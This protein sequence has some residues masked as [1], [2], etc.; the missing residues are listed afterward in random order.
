MKT[1]S[2]TREWTDSPVIFCKRLSPILFSQHLCPVEIDICQR[3]SVSGYRLVPVLPAQ[4]STSQLAEWP[5]RQYKSSG[6]GN[7]DCSATGA[8]ID[9]GT[10]SAAPELAFQKACGGDQSTRN[11]HRPSGKKA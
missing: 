1:R 7:M 10:E 8:L 2:I 9:R 4:K 6:L 3:G 11:S 5:R